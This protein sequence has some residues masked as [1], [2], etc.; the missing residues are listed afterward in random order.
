MYIDKPYMH[1]CKHIWTLTQ[2]QSLTNQYIHKKYGYF[3]NVHLWHFPWPKCPWPKCPGRN[4]HGRNVH[5]RNILH[6]STQSCVLT[7]DLCTG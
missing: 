4:V 6:S 2:A 5:G 1:A 7:Y 3:Q